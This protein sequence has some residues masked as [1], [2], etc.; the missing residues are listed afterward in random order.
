PSIERVCLRPVRHTGRSR[1]SVLSRRQRADR[2]ER[3]EGRADRLRRPQRSLTSKVV[4]VTPPS[5]PV[6]KA[7]PRKAAVP[8][9]TSSVGDRS[10]SPQHS[11][12]IPGH[13]SRSRSPSSSSSSSSVSG[14]S[15]D[16][17]SRHRRRR[18]RSRSRSLQKQRARSPGG[19]RRG[20]RDRGYR[21]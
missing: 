8:S 12:D 9:G 21:R 6:E 16:P 7:P 20:H 2:R 14:Y 15:S 19:D 3:C 11:R 5:P 17:E 1:R 10:R 13:P 4:F 18:G